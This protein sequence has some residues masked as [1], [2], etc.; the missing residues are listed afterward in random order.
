MHFESGMRGVSRCVGALCCDQWQP[1][2]GLPPAPLRCCRRWAGTADTSWV[3]PAQPSALSPQPPGWPPV[4]PSGQ[5]R[6]VWGGSYVLKSKFLS[7]S[8]QIAPSMFCDFFFC[9]SS[10]GSAK[11]DGGGH[12]PTSSQRIWTAS[13][14]QWLLFWVYICNFRIQQLQS[15]LLSPLLEPDCA[16]ISPSICP[17]LSPP[18]QSKK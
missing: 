8:R 11:G 5:P 2:P 4:A 14:P 13:F 16:P 12:G 17:L 9:N 18:F 10:S 15:P 7:P 6:M 1:F 3:P